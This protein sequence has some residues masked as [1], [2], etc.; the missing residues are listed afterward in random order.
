MTAPPRINSAMLGFWPIQPLPL[1]SPGPIRFTVFT[2]CSEV[3]DSSW[4]GKTGTPSRKPHAA[5][6]FLE[7]PNFG[8]GINN[9]HNFC[10]FILATALMEAYFHPVPGHSLR[11]RLKHY[12][13]IATLFCALAE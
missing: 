2:R 1:S 7:T 8:S 9:S 3:L 6:A 5:P 12:L 11:M 13:Y 10:N 4:N